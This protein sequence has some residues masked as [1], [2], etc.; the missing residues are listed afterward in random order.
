MS[1]R[2]NRVKKSRTR[3]MISRKVGDEC[4][5]FT[6]S[7][8]IRSA[9]MIVVAPLATAA[10]QVPT[11]ISAG[12]YAAALKCALFSSI[13]FLILAMSTSLADLFSR[14]GET[15]L[16]YRYSGNDKH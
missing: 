14:L 11:L 1:T 8:T 15:P 12:N 6:L 5:T 2:R 7:N 10:Y 3:R 16:N 9:R 13:S 4:K